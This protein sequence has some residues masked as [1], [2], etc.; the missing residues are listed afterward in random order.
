[1]LIH[2]TTYFV[3]KV[4]QQEGTDRPQGTCFFHISF[5]ISF[6]WKKKKKSVGRI[7]WDCR[8]GLDPLRSRDNMHKQANI[9]IKWSI[10][11]MLLIIAIRMC[12]VTYNW[13][14]ETQNL[15]DC[16]AVMVSCKVKLLEQLFKVWGFKYL[17]VISI[18][19]KIIKKGW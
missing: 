13:P 14:N 5:V 18:S 9:S 17:P 16:T 6:F 3:E 8:I 2:G 19:P 7:S 1:M 10:S 15:S 11:D 4:G 12:I